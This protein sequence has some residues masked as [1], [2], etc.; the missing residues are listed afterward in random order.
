MPPL[1][2]RTLLP[3]RSVRPSRP[4]TSAIA[5]RGRASRAAPRRSAGSASTLRSRSSVGRWNTTPMAASAA[6]GAPAR[7]WPQTTMRPSRAENSRVISA[8]SV[9]LPAPFGPSR[10]VNR[11]AGTVKLTWSRALTRGCSRSSPPRS[12]SATSLMLQPSSW[13]HPPY[14]PAGTAG[15]PAGSASAP[16]GG[17]SGAC[18]R[19]VR[20]MTGGQ[21]PHLACWDPPCPP[22]P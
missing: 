10:A 5:G 13:L 6:R 12:S 11:R 21:P 22:P 7:S 8:I 18:W 15:H 17:A 1:S 20:P 4:S 3:A 14:R 2:V 9:V 19:R 16:T